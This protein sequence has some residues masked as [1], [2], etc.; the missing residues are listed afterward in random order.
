MSFF[1]KFIFV[2]IGRSK[3]SCGGSSQPFDH[4]CL[5]GKVV[6]VFNVASLASQ[7]EEAEASLQVEA[8]LGGSHR[9]AAV[10]VVLVVVVVVVDDEGRPVVQPHLG[11]FRSLT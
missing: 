3:C 2:S 9:T 10:V 5:L 6:R 7:V 11:A 8:P 4:H 1:F